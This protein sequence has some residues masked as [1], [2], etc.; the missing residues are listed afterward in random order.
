MRWARRGR[1]LFPL[2]RTFFYI[3]KPPTLL[4]YDEIA[5]VEFERQGGSLSLSSAKT[6]DIRVRASPSPLPLL[7]L[8]SAKTFDI[9][10]RASPSPLPLLRQDVRHPGACRVLRRSPSIPSRTTDEKQRRFVFVVPTF[11]E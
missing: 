9:R 11:G 2:E 4:P 3:S 10:V 6:F 1:Y 8:S 5:E 7:S